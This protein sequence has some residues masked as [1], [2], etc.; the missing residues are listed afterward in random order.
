MSTTTDIPGLKACLLAAVALSISMTLAACGGGNGSGGG[1]GGG[2]APT[3]TVGGSVTGLASGTL[4]LQDNSA[5]DA[6]TVTASGAFTLPGQLASGASYDVTVS[7]APSGVTCTVSGGSG[8]IQA[9][10]VSGVAVS[11]SASVAHQAALVFRSG[12]ETV[13]AGTAS[14]AITLQAVDANG[15]VAGPTTPI[16]LTSSSPTMTFS[17]TA[18]FATPITSV[19]LIASHVS[20]YFRD[21]S[22]GSPTIQASTPGYADATLAETVVTSIAGRGTV[23][24]LAAHVGSSLPLI[25]GP[26]GTLYGIADSVLPQTIF[27]IDSLGVQK[28]L[29]TFDSN[30][31]WYPSSGLTRASDGNFYGVTQLGT[32]TP[33]GGIYRL[34]PDGTFSVIYAFSGGADGNWP[35]GSL[36]QGADGRLYGT[37]SLGG[38]SCGTAFALTLTGQFTLL[39]QFTNPTDGCE[40]LAGLIQGSDGLLYGT[41]SQGG[42]GSGQGTVYS[43]TSSG[44]VAVLHALLVSEGSYPSGALLEAS[45]GSLYGIAAQGGPTTSSR[46]DVFRVTKAGVFTVLYG[47][48]SNT[49]G[50]LDASFSGTSRSVGTLIQLEDGNLYG[51]A[52]AGGAFGDGALFQI[53]P[54]GSEVVI[55][56][57]QNNTTLPAGA[58]CAA[59]LEGLDG[60]LYGIGLNGGPGASGTVFSISGLF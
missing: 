25:Q 50:Q 15:N 13:N 54:S 19:S 43:M 45:D 55:Q 49:Q 18:D 2:A 4:V 22:T 9:S 40:P 6:V 21:A 7:Q 1:S 30:V 26:D 31:S 52:D 35:Q 44:Q 23:T 36:L 34:T 60:K 48:Q 10:N 3:Y 33:H 29:H 32:S 38:T 59:L 28:I 37:A 17:A 14:G 53:T 46:G 16:Q 5:A 39:H 57:F 8:A 27:S 20:F 12:G 11:C 47:F 51:V 24:E 41:T 56:S 58:P 42:P